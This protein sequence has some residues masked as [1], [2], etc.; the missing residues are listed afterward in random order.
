MS[1]FIDKIIYI[2]LE[3]RKDRKIQIEHELDNYELSYERFSAIEI[4]D[5]G[6]LGCGYSH[7]AVL[8]LA[9]ERGYNNILILEDDFMFI[10]SKKEFENNLQK[11]FDLKLNFDVCML[12]YMNYESQNKTTNISFLS[13]IFQCSNASAYLVN[14]QYYDK[15]ID[16][17]E[18][19]LPK[20]KQTKEHWKYANDIS[21]FELQN[22]DNWYGFLPQLGKQRITGYS[23]T[24]CGI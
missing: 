10:V 8:K 6:I 19:N 14:N 15:L 3:K 7:L 21:W 20:L 5:Q 12:V 9:K 22:K 23:D 18:L 13:K 17:L 24:C 16:I 2:N 11:L 1:K 4:K